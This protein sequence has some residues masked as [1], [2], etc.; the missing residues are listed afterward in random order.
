MQVGYGV[1]SVPAGIY[2]ARLVLTIVPASS[3]GSLVRADAQ[4]IWFPPRTAAEY[5]DPARYHVLVIAITF[6]NPRLH[7]IDKVVTSQAAI[8]QLAEALDQSPVEPVQPFCPLIFATYRLGFS[9]SLHSRPVVVVSATRWPCGG[10][11]IS[12]D[13]RPQPPLQDA[14]IVVTTADRLL[15]VNPEPPGQQTGQASRGA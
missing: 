10:A 4:V 1:R 12:I 13:G 3:G 7:T 11:K 2:Q 6:F 15:G 5:I 14:N 9:V 8:T